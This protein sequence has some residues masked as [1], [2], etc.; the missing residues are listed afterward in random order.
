MA[1]HLSSLTITHPAI[2]TLEE[3][4]PDHA[5]DFARLDNPISE[6]DWAYWEANRR[7]AERLMTQYGLGI[8]GGAVRGSG[9]GGSIAGAGEN[10]R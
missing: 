4:H 10:T 7:E 9:L 5:R 1:R 3:Q 2:P 6:Q 8:G